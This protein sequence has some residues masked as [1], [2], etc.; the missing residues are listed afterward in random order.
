M[1]KRFAYH[2]V[3]LSNLD[4]SI[5]FYQDLMHMKLERTYEVAGEALEEATGFPGAHIK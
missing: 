5:V 4:R 3:T 1:L 2:G